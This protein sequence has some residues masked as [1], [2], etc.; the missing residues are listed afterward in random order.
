MRPRRRRVAQVSALLLVVLATVVAYLSSPGGHGAGP[1]W[2]AR[3]GAAPPASARTVTIA[4]APTWA[5]H[6][7]AEDRDDGAPPP[8]KVSFERATDLWQFANDAL[9]QGGLGPVLEG[10]AAAGECA[11]VSIEAEALQAMA[12]GASAPGVPGEV[13]DARRAAI[14]EVLSRC[15][16][17]VAAGSE[18]SVA[19]RQSFAGAVDAGLQGAEGGTAA[20]SRLLLASGSVD[21][22]ERVL[23]P[24]AIRWMTLDG[25]AP[26]SPAAQ[27]YW[28]AVHGAVCDLGLDCSPSGWRATAACARL[29]RCGA[30]LDPGLAEDLPAERATRM[31]A[32]RARLVRAVTLRDWAA[33]G[34]A[35]EP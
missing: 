2:R 7:P 13:T 28:D 27:A 32:L 14:Q 10:R 16:G 24:V 18:A 5:P 26:D 9:R 3:E 22:Q 12:G 4:A 34:L 33:L 8:A 19:L 21:A 6:R 23:T 15:A 17:F 11:Q 20:R 35:T 31:A 25:V 1:S 30:G 29:G